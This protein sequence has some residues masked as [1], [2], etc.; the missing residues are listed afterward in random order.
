[1]TDRT[2]A[3]TAARPT[4]V[5]R[6]ARSRA[7]RGSA[8][9]TRGGSSAAGSASSSSSSAGRHG[10]RQAAGRVQD[11]R[12]GRPEG[13]RPHRVAVPVRAGRRAEHRLR[14]ARRAAARHARAQGG[15]RGRGRAAQ[16]PR[17]QARGRQGRH[18]E[19]RRPVQP[20]HVLRQ[21]AHRL[22]RGAVR[23]D[24]R[25]QGPRPRSSPWRR[26]SAQTRRAGR[27]DGRVQRRGR[28]PADRAGRVRAARAA[29]GDHRA[30]DRLPHVLGDAR[31]RSRSRSR[32]W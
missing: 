7:G 15:D 14:R 26:P 18:R 1:M 21:R 9:R 5:R 16:D 19:R 10:R 31:S 11:P 24:D 12:V 3:A 13:D 8:R 20:G 22:R 17:V 32:R 2:R 25:G 23:P 30:A 6:P 4:S 29:R 28:V 27:R